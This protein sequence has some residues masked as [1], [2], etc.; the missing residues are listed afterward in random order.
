MALSKNLKKTLVIGSIVF[1]SLIILVGVF[2]VMNLFKS[3]LS[4]TFY[5]SNY[6]EG[7]APADED[8]YSISES[9]EKRSMEL[10]SYNYDE[11]NVDS[12]IR[13]SGSM[14]I[15]VD[16]LESSN[17]EVL[18]ILKGFNGSVVSSSQS[19]TG[20]NK[21]IS[22]TLKVPVEYFED[23]Y[24]TIKDIDGELEYASYYTDDVTQEYVDLESRLKNLEATETQL[25]KI[26]DTA[27]TVEDT[28]AVYNQLTS[29]RSQIEVIKGQLKYLDNQVDYSYL[30]VT[31]S[32]SDIGKDVKDE[33]WEPLGVL[34]NAV[35]S[36]VD[37]GI[38]IVD[39]LIWVVV[40]S[41]VVLIPAFIIISIVKKKAKKE[42]KMV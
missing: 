2:V 18:S 28:L 29:T 21:S 34:K 8:S 3:T 14:N 4:E 23:L 30:T 32:L 40:F 6:G 42:E 38:F 26:L 39:S 31:L 1:G 24:E 17:D 27:E 41:P 12:K 36:L 16:D 10:D 13:K 22:I 11:A 25:V 35:A 37:F 9:F 7:I 15:T 33:K 20:N 19:G 5:N